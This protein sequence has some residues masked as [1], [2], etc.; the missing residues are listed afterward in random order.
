MDSILKVLSKLKPKLYAWWQQPQKEMD[1]RQEKNDIQPLFP[2][3][4]DAK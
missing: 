3:R 2:P 4:D 1:L